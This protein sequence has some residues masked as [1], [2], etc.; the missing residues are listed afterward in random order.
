MSRRHVK[1]FRPDEALSLISADREGRALPCP[2]CG[3]AAV[4]R[5]P[6]RPDDGRAVSGPVTLSCPAC[7]R[8]VSYIDRASPTKA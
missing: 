4:G 3:A 5:S 2:C 6:G 7:G 8:I 1:E